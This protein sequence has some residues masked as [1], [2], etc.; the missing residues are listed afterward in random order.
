MELLAKRGMGKTICPSEVARDLAG[1]DGDWRLLMDA[2][3]CAVD[4]LQA[5]GTVTLSWRGRPLE[6]RDGPYRIA[7]APK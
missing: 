7:C 3:H 5:R 6:Q 2:V 1:P 4:T